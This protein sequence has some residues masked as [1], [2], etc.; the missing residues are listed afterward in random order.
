MPLETLI[1]SSCGA[2]APAASDEVGVGLDW[3][4]RLLMMT[5]RL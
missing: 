4:L 5:L 3:V 2:G 1:N